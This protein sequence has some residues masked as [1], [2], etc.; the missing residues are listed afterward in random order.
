M[1]F[2]YQSVTGTLS[3]GTRIHV[4][5]T[6]W[7]VRRVTDNRP[8]KRIEAIAISGIARGKE[9]IFVDRLE[10]NLKIVDPVD[11]D[12]VTDTSSA[13]ED[14]KLYLE[15]AFR[16]SSPTGQ[17]PFVVGEAAIDDLPF[18]HDPVKMAL[19]QA[20]VRLLIA[21]DVGLGKTLEAGL[22]TSELLLRRR[23]SRILVVATRSMLTQFQKEFWSRFAIPLTRLDSAAIQKARNIIPT[24]HNP[25]D[26]FEKA[27]ISI[28]TLK[29]DAQ[30]R[31]ALEDAYWDLII[32]DEAHNVA[33]RRASSG[34]RSMR[35]K[36]A[37]LLSRR[38]DAL[39]LLTAT[40]HDGSHRSFSSL[41]Q[42]L[43]QT[44][45][46]NPDHITREEIEPF[47]IRRFR[48]SPDVRRDL[49]SKVPERQM[50]R[51]DHPLTVQEETVY[52]LVAGLKLDM[53]E[54]RK[55]SRRGAGDE[56]FRTT[57]AKALLSSPAA[58]IS[59]LRNRIQRIAGDHVGGTANDVAALREII[60]ALETIDDANYSKYQ[61][62]L[63]TVGKSGWKKSAAD[64]RLLIFSERIDTVRWLR[65]A[66]ARDLGLAEGQIEA[67]DGSG[68]GSDIRVQKIVED[69]GQRNS[70]I[71]VLVATDMVSEGLNLHYQCSRLHH[72]DLP[73]SMLRF[74]QRNGRID[75]YGQERQ[76][77]IWF[78][79]GET[80]HE[81]VG[82]IRILTVLAEK[83]ERA[84]EGIKDPSIFFGTNDAEEQEAMLTKA[85]EAGESTEELSEELDQIAHAETG[86]DEHD[87][88]ALDDILASLSGAYDAPAP[89]DAGAEPTSRPPRL[90]PSAFG[91]T[92]AMLSRLSRN[93]E[94]EVEF[95]LVDEDVIQLKLPQDMYKRSL[96]GSAADARV[97]PRFMP[98]EVVPA[99]RQI[100]L[101]QSR[102][103]ID[104]AVIRARLSDTSWPDTQ[105]LWDIHPIVD[106]L[107]DQAANLF[108]RR[109][110]P[111]CG[112]TKGLSLGET[113][114]L[115]HGVVPNLIGT[116]VVDHW[117]IVRVTSDRQTKLQHVMAFLE[118]VGLTGTVPNPGN[119]NPEYVRGALGPAVY[120]FQEETVG[121][122]RQAQSRLNA[123]NERTLK[124][125]ERLEQRHVEQLEFRFGTQTED[126][127][128]EGKK[129]KRR[130]EIDTWFK[131]WREWFDG[132]CHLPD[133]PNP[134]VKIIAAF[135]A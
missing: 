128:T 105:Y 76:P 65:D 130:Q 26:Q 22:V 31:T 16:S 12:L 4:R 98:E 133:D 93:P 119:G 51:I 10:R 33:E 58:C 71:R 61:K 63:E 40:P 56:L 87:F 29:N 85:F 14:T 9:A 20:R 32:I 95:S 123:L 34:G 91:F 118:E 68:V 62:L 54:E 106:W 15:A 24:N 72:F 129:R 55:S 113:A 37:R 47:V 45:V 57:I 73:W 94:T 2:D 107:S 35:S 70:R 89:E 75:R 84:R 30:Y 92:R 17:S 23:A 97:D 43:D 53:D 120:R 59:T 109:T 125:L 69:F 50:N 78:Y 1:E 25:F 103:V 83:D 104:E 46:A 102:L 64:D 115:L 77:R 121:L 27:I 52:E 134:F 101:T 122:R 8:G 79:A 5:D 13:F 38:S 6:E 114:I 11:V 36:L 127:R 124:D 81:K 41:I 44:A 99:S 48:T 116:P 111:V 110:V 19:G 74:I 90:Y 131:S 132:R 7:L 28:D 135:H 96:F 117:G 112:L 100:K 67:L 21:D 86:D 88:S 18:Q 66:L 49:K 126:V 3:A 82:D 42:M 39:L 60:A 108:D 80:E